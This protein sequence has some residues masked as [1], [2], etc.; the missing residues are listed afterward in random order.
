MRPSGIVMYMASSMHDRMHEIVAMHVLLS[1][2]MGRMWLPL[3]RPT[4]SLP[5]ECKLCY[6][7]VPLVGSETDIIEEMRVAGSPV[8]FKLL[9]RRGNCRKVRF[10]IAY[11]RSEVDAWQAMQVSFT[12]SNG[13]D[14]VIK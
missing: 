14:A 13:K 7:N 10:A 2:Q 12:W 9:I 3:P 6:W 8:P 5:D 1:A 11:F 4:M